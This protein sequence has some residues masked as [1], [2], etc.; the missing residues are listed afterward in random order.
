MASQN[1]VASHASEGTGHQFPGLNEATFSSLSKKLMEKIQSHA[2]AA[3]KVAKEKKSNMTKPASTG[4]SAAKTNASV[5]H[6]KKRDSTGRVLRHKSDNGQ[7][8]PSPGQHEDQAELRQEIELLG[9]TQADYDL[10]NGVESGSEIEDQSAKQPRKSSKATENGKIFEKD[11]SSI[12]KEFSHAPQDDVQSTDSD[13]GSDPERVDRDVDIGKSQFN[14]KASGSIP[15]P[16]AQLSGKQAS[17]ASKMILDPQPEWFSIPIHIPKRSTERLKSTP[18]AIVQALHNEAKV[19]L[20]KENAAFQQLQQSTSSSSTKFY[21]QVMTSG[22]LTDKV[23]ALTLS[24]QESP[25]HNMKA[26]ETLLGLARKR[27]RAQALE[28]LR[29]LKDLVAQGTLL[30]SDRRLVLFGQ[31]PSLLSTL[32]NVKS[33]TQ[34]DPLPQGLTASALMLWAYEDWLKGIYFE[35]L[36]VLESWCNDEL[37]FSKARAVSYIYE[38]LREKPEQESNLLH[39]LIN[40]LGD[41]VKKIASRTSYLLLQLESAHPAMK[42]TIVSAIETELLLRP[43]QSLHANYYAVITLNQTVLSSREETVSKNLLAIYFRLFIAMLNPVT[44]EDRSF[45]PRKLDEEGK[46]KRRGKKKSKNS[47]ENVQLE[48]LREKV[49]SAILTGVNRAYPYAGADPSTLTDHVDTLFKITHSSNFNTSIQAMMLIQQL[50]ATHE[51][52]S[53]RFYRTL[54]ESLLDPRLASSSKQALY[55]NLLY[56]ALKADLDIKRVKAFSKRIMQVLT[57]QQPSF[58]CGAMYLLHELEGTF[59]SLAIM[60]DEPEDHDDGEETFKDVDDAAD[61]NQNTADQTPS[62]TYDSRK[63]DPRHARAD[64]ACLWELSPFLSHF[65]PSVSVGAEHLMN[66]EALSGKPDLNLHT[67]SHFL[68][69]FVYRNPKISQTSSSRGSSM[70]QPMAGSESSVLLV[71]GKAHRQDLPINMQTSLDKSEG[72]MKPEDAFFHQYFKSLG[73]DKSKQKTKETRKEKKKAKTDADSNE[74]A[75]EAEEQEIWGAMMQ[76]QPEL[77]GAAGGDG[78]DFDSDDDGLEMSDLDSDY[79]RNDE[80]SDDEEQDED[81]EA[82]ENMAGD[83]EAASSDALALDDDEDDLLSSLAGDES[84]EEEVDVSTVKKQTKKSGSGLIELPLADEK[85]GKRRKKLKNLPTFASVEDYMDLVE[86]EEGEEE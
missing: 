27:S 33:W 15:V 30:P 31:Q 65:H 38:L 57:L 63:R 2:P 42:G 78:A 53:D 73:K 39:M 41:P 5:Q 58:I 71:G 77:E 43:N 85:G 21:A 11:L 66:H 13:S 22:T 72:D 70:M 17:R 48:E 68:D 7:Q 16:S 35:V 83:A 26:L 23:S 19:M 69:R 84:S 60:L 82:L 49:I 54:Y 80:D 75:E 37:E 51:V 29:A 76:S 81:E 8:K 40:K 18:T 67:L 79:S 10:V 1:D 56:K 34:S 36:K 50:S 55:M 45:K 46:Q 25:I 24:V 61:A 6:G 9:G 20:E 32:Q 59:P 62:L 74:E 4:K 47:H 3:T 12:L 52:A 44:L 28:V 86:D 64:N 14:S